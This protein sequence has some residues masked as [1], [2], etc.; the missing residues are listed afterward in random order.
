VWRHRQ[1]DS[2]MLFSGVAG[3]SGLIS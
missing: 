3:S 2:K 1:A